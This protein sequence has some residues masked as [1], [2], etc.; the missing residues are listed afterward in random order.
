VN[1]YEWSLQ[2]VQ[3]DVRVYYSGFQQPPERDSVAALRAS[4]EGL[5]FLCQ[6]RRSVGGFDYEA[7]RISRRCA[8]ALGLITEDKRG[9]VVREHRADFWERLQDERRS[10]RKLVR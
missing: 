5:V 4:A 8:K 1:V 3:G 2:A 6:R 10:M 7:H 9:E